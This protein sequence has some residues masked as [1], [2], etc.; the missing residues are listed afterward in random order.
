M[1]RANQGDVNYS[2]GQMYLWRWRIVRKG[3]HC[4]PP[5]LRDDLEY[6]DL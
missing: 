5:I 6:G 2:V 4:F 1:S 3:R